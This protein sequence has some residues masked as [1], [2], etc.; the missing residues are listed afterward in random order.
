MTKNMYEIN[1]HWTENYAMKCFLKG[2][3]YIKTNF[4]IYLVVCKAVRI[5]VFTLELCLNLVIRNGKTS[6]CFLWP[7][8]QNYFW[9]WKKRLKPEVNCW[10][11]H[12]CNLNGLTYIKW[13]SF[14]SWIG[15]SWNKLFFLDFS[16]KVFVLFLPLV[17]NT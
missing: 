16:L 1:Q 15:S 13:L 12:G 14:F 17:Q 7:W 10:L 6:F 9:D 5:N 2:L 11:S 4:F 3:I 8:S